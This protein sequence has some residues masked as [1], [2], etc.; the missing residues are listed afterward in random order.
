MAHQVVRRARE[1][2]AATRVLGG[3][4][5]VRSVQ[6]LELGEPPRDRRTQLVGVRGQPQVAVPLP[7]LEVL[8]TA[9]DD[10]RPLEPGDGERETAQCVVDVDEELGACVH[11][12][13]RQ[14]RQ[15]GHDARVFE[16]D[17]RD[18]DRARPRSL[19]REALRERRPPGREP[20]DFELLLREPASCRRR[21]WNSPSVETSFGRAPS[22]SADRNRS[23]SS[24]V[25]PASATGAPG[26]ASGSRPLRTRSASR[27]RGPA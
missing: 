24:C 13:L 26:S 16:E 5:L 3:A 9:A 20:D 15:L 25:F 1:A 12:R 14:R 17:G 2:H 8:V 10:P 27:T 23:T 11:A 7:E 18:E 4:G 6:L 22:G 19:G 21:V